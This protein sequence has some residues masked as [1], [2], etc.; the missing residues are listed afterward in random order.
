[1]RAALIG[2]LLAAGVGQQLARVQMEKRE[3]V[4]DE[5][6]VDAVGVV[7]SARIVDGLEW[8]AIA[9]EDIHQVQVAFGREAAMLRSELGDLDGGPSGRQMQ[10]Q[11]EV[12]LQAVGDELAA[13]E[14][15]N[16]AEASRID[17]TIVDP[18]FEKLIDHADDHVDRYTRAAESTRKTVLWIGWASTLAVLAVLGGLLWLLFASRDRQIAR[19]HEVETDRRLR[20]VVRGST[21]AISIVSGDD[22]QTVLNPSQG[23]L[24]ALGESPEPVR[25]GDLLSSDQYARWAAADARVREGGGTHVL[26]L[27]VQRPDG[28]VVHVEAHGSCL[29]DG[30]EERVW[31]WRDVTER[32]ELEL[33]L[34]HQSL[35]DPL[36]GV[37]NRA[38]LRDR[39]DHALRRAAR[40]GSPV[41]VLFCD[42]D[43]FKTLNDSLG[44]AAGDDILGIVAA[45]LGGCVRDSDTVARYGGDEFAI[46]LEDVDTETASALAERILSVVSYEVSI[47]TR[48]LHPSVSIGIATA[49]PDTTTDDL[50]RNADIAMYTAKRSGKGRAAVFQETMAEI[51]S[52]LLDLHVDLR[53]A[54]D[55][56]QLSLHYQPILAL[57]DGTVEGV[58]ALIRWEHPTRGNIEPSVFIPVAEATGM[59]IPIGQWVVVE[60]CRAAVD[61]Q[62]GRS[63]SLRMNVNVS[64]EQLHDPTFVAFVEQTL[65]ESGL[66]PALLVLEVTEG[67]LLDSDTA[68]ER[69]AEL[70]G[71]GVLIAI[72]D[73]GTGYASIN[74]LQRLPVDILKIDK[75]F[76]SGDAL[77]A[78]ERIAFLNA[79]VGIAKSL[80]IVSL[81]EGVEEGAELREL[82][83]LGC[84]CGQGYYWARPVPESQLAST[85]DAVNERKMMAM[86]GASMASS[87]RMWWAAD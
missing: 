46:L 19:R 55:A 39:A 44:H 32:K 9:G 28:T 63:A 78:G 7:A 69:L 22:L 56:G 36:T 8:R 45:R 18:A 82:Q 53:K 20:A 1:M 47:Q 84:D 71:L 31:I 81:A 24:H 64:P 10:S 35:H 76:V 21:D 60:A 58:E 4:A 33:Q 66:E 73:F 87:V 5:G 75:S 80:H 48:V 11:A 57:A 17:G 25:L 2:L 29:E 85:I 6:V 43:D 74:Y 77:P 50:V 49:S 30:S 16:R 61:L 34:S 70:H 83:D 68:V 59:I 65:R 14:A 79:I 40:T 13:L 52:G 38:L 15:G 72:D 67:Y 42:I 23:S 41:S 37:A 27:D 12:Y 86:P 3:E 54:L 26:E 62:K 51:P